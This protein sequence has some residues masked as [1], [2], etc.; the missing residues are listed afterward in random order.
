MAVAAKTNPDDAK[1]TQIRDRFAEVFDFW[2]P[3]YKDGDLNMRFIAGNPWKDEDRKAREA[4]GRPVVTFDE[5][6]QYLNQ[7]VN[8]VRAN[9]RAPMFSPEGDG[10]NDDTARFYGNHFRQIEYRSNA[11]VA[12]TTAY[13]NA[14]QRGYGFVRMVA[15]YEHPR[16]Q[17]QQLRIKAV[18]NPSACYPDCDALSDPDGTGWKDFFYIESY[19]QAEFERAFPDAEFTTF[20]AEQ[21]TAVGS[22]WMNKGRVQVAEYW[23][24]EQQDHDLVTVEVPATLKKPQR[25]VS[26]VEGVDKKPRGG[27]EIQRRGTTIPKVWCYLT[28]GVEL[29]KKPGQK[30]KRQAWDGAS[31]PFAACYGK[32]VW[33]NEGDGPKLKILAM[34]TLARE[35]YAAYCFAVTSELEAVGTITKNPYWAYEHQLSQDMM[36]AIAGSLHQPVAVLLAKATIPGVPN[37][38]LPLPQRNPLSVDLSAFTI[39]RENARRAIQAAMGWTPLPAQMQR[40]DPKLSGKAIDKLESSGQKGSYHFIDHYNDML[41]RVGVIYEECADKYYDTDRE[42]VTRTP[43]GK[44]IKVRINAKDQAEGTDDLEVLPSIAGRHAVTVDI[45]PEVE[46]ER[47]AA[48]EFLDSFIGSPLMA[49]IEPAKRDKLMALG[50]RQQMLG[51]IGTQMADVID[52][53]KKGDGPDPQELQAALQQAE[54]QIIPTLQKEIEFLSQK[55]EAKEIEAQSRERIAADANQ[56]KRDIA[57]LTSKDKR[58]AT[59]TGADTAIEVQDMKNE[60]D[61][62]RMK[63]DAMLARQQMQHTERVEGAR[64]DQQTT[65]TERGHQET[66]VEGDKARHAASVESE[67]TR[68]HASAEGA[69]NRKAAEKTAK[70]KQATKAKKGS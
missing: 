20:S 22:R 24:V 15:E 8:E 51:P 39:T 37:V 35:P 43:D 45:G 44:S 18:P 58:H 40:D 42:V 7:A 54:Q 55:L 4:A 70:A 48:K 27:K 53:Q 1:V 66:S 46:S 63:L 34:T 3:I 2:D 57:A 60:I 69:E 19:S 67:R 50:I 61:V 29:L 52:P 41:R 17:V 38:L 49:N 33:L 16:S 64:L 30:E 31:I 11:Q 25:V 13:E 6:G 21:M 65:M 59:D 47:T 10:A 62:M 5:L 56:T 23:E 14:L 68:Q 26:Y 9:P 28:N 12:Y 36:D 32:M